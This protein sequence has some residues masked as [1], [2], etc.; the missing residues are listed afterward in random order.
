MDVGNAATNVIPGSARAGFNIRFNDHHTGA[1]LKAWLKTTL[2][3]AA[4]GAH[5]ELNV[6]ISGE[7]FITPPG[8]LSTLVTHAVKDITGRVPE[9]STTGGTSDARFIKDVCPVCEF[10]LVGLTMHKADERCALKDLEDLTAIY[11]RMLERY[12]ETS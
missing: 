10:G 2:D 1:K 7:S 9:L 11:R 6:R 4:N 3:A 5:Y 12:F 8:A